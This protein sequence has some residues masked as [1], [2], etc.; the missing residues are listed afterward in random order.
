[1]LLLPAGLLLLVYFIAPLLYF[2][3]YS[4]RP[5]STTGFAGGGLTLDNFTA[6]FGSSFL[7][8]TLIRSVAIAAIATVAT[9]VI[10]LPVAYFMV[11]SRPWLKGLLIILAVFPLLTGSVVRSIGWVAILGYSGLLNFVLTSLHVTASPLDI[12]QT[13][14]SVTVVIVS[15]VV[16]VTILV[17]HAAMESVDPSTEQAALSLGAGRFRTFWQVTM[18]QIIP[19]VTAATSLVFVLSVNAYSTPLLVGSSRIPMIAPQIYTVI[20]AQGNLPGGAAMSVI[21]VVIS[22]ALVAV[23][24]L[25]MRLLFD[26]W[27][28]TT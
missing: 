8:A 12:L 6:F 20:T 22:V 15:V 11:K 7:V 28:A 27:R 21:V 10:S 17:L 5:T 25:T 1:L 19:G 16:P 9:L 3:R 24:G 13:T 18:P 14:G 4:I 2:F 26:R 23:Y